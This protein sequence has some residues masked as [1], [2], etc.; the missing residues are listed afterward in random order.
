[1]TYRRKT[2]QEIKAAVQEL[3]QEA[4]NKVEE[5]AQDSEGIR[6]YLT[7]MS[8][9]YQ[10]SPRNNALIKESFEGALAVKGFKQ[11]KEEGFSVRKGEKPL[12]FS[13][14]VLLNITKIQKGSWSLFRQQILLQ[15]SAFRIKKFL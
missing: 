14:Q 5:Y 8:K 13:F 3:S 2:V 12:K 9:F 15:R 11:W 7:F 6:A 1:M 10:Y 4:K